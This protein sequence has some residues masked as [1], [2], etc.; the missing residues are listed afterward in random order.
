MD[1]IDFYREAIL[2]AKKMDTKYRETLPPTIRDAMLIVSDDEAAQEKKKRKSRKKKLGKDGLY[3]EERDF[4][5][6][7]WKDRGSLE[8]SSTA[9]VSREAEMKKHV[10]DLRLRETQLQILLILETM[11]L[12]SAVTS[13]AKIPAEGENADRPAEDSTKKTKGKKPQ[14]LN[15][16]LELHLDRLC[17]WHAVSFDDLAIPESLKDTENSHLSGK[18]AESD[19]VRDFC[20]EVI[21]P[22][23][24][25]RLPDKCKLI[26]RKF[27]VSSSTTPKRP[28][29]T[30]AAK[31]NPR[32]SNPKRQQQQQQQQAHVQQAQNPRRTLQRVLTDEQ[33]SQGRRPSLMRHKTAPSKQ[34]NP[35]DSMEPLLPAGGANVRGGIQKAAKRVDN[36]EVDLNAAARQHE[37]KLR[38]V[39]ILME[40][41]KELDAAIHTL[42]RPNRELVAK[43]FADDADK[44]VTSGGGSARKQKNPVRNPMGQGVQ[45][46]ATPKGSRKKDMASAGFAIPPPSLPRGFPGPSVDHRVNTASSSPPGDG[47]A[48]LVPNSAARPGLFSGPRMSSGDMGAIQET[49]TRRP[50]KSF[51]SFPKNTGQSN[52]PSGGLFRV[53]SHPSVQSTEMAT[54]STPISSRRARVS[55]PGP[56]SNPFEQLQVKSS[57]IS[58]TPPRK[59][60]G[61][62]PDS[63]SSAFPPGP[64]QFGVLSTP[65][66]GSVAL[67]TPVKATTGSGGDTLPSTAVE[68]NPEK[69]IYEQLGW[70]DDDELGL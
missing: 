34:D 5:R 69:S 31:K 4:V 59:Q 21:V 65:V 55:V 66:K 2:P 64:P 1:L 51:E 12:E 30:T 41:K 61:M 9:D 23:Y 67:D 57:T 25:A 18:K 35:R 46:M 47:D 50:A 8:N 37:T 14:D 27:G 28:Q 42:R 26:T 54:P 38:K 17:I 60:P 40:Q 62:V 70:S 32:D 11:A 45:V 58:E 33:S 24:A 63:T 20:K 36:R 13:E 43:D 7:W 53:P 52:Y 49:P 10:A 22:F 19:A 44:R 15:V 6:R 29:S 48:Q 68:T 39:Q 16:V 3:P 56:T